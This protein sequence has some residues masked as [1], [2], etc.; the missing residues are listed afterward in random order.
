ML[1]KHWEWPEASGRKWC[2]ERD[3]YKTVYLA[4][5]D[6]KTAFDVAK[7]GLIADILEETGAH[8]WMI[9]AMPEEMKALEEGRE[10][11]RVS[12]PG[13][14]ISGISGVSGRKAWRRRRCGRNW[15]RL[16]WRMF[17]K[18]REEGVCGLGGREGGME[19]S[20]S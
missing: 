5:L 19:W 2:T 6:G 10:G 15:Q 1:L 20:G 4:S 18:V 11:E 9:A 16:F 17:R 14:R 7:A 8:G 3:T 12:N 13:K